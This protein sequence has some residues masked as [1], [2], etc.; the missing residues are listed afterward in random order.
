[1]TRLNRTQILR[2]LVY[3]RLLVWSRPYSKAHI[4]QT[5]CADHS[6]ASETQLNELISFDLTV[7]TRQHVTQQGQS[8]CI[9]ST[10]IQSTLI[11]HCDL[12]ACLSLSKPSAI[13]CVAVLAAKSLLLPSGPCSWGLYLCAASQAFVER[14]FSVCS[15]LCNGPP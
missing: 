4:Q 7:T 8:F 5:N 13:R 6:V 3:Y 2:T 15:I 14:I 1:M 9:N 11:I 10:V 12:T